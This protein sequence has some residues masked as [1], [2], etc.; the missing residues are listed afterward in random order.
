MTPKLAPDA[1][2]S[3]P[4]AARYASVRAA[5][6]ALAAPLSAEDCQVQSMADASPT[7]W[8]LAHVTWFFETFLLERF[9][10]GFAPFD[11]AFRVLF[12]SY[13]QGVGEQHARPERGLLTRPSLHEVKAWRA[14]I[15]E[16][17]QTLLRHH[18][19]PLLLARIALGL[20]H[21]QQHQELLLTDIKHAFS[22]TPLHKA[23]A[24]RWPMTSVHAQP[25]RWLGFDGGL[26][27]HGFD[28]ARDGA[29]S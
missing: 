18:A 23:Y 25:L 13:Y 19:D 8:H 29:F 4:L 20:Q 14:E 27:E 28:A 10:A 16:R 26:I 17:V 15:D 22:F 21:E 9:E 5:S 1:A 7:K 11:P 2:R 24:K 3:G 12:N 6:L